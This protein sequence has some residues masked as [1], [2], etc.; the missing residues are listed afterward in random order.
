MYDHLIYDFDG[1]ISDTYPVFTRSLLEL[2]GRRGIEGDYDTAYAC[3]KVSVGHALRH[4]NVTEAHREFSKIHKAM[5]LDEQ[6]AFPEA[7]GILREALALG[8]KNYIYTH[9]GPL[10]RKLL[11]RMGLLDYFEFVLDGSYN[12]PN[13]PAPDGLNFLIDKFGIDRSRALMI[14]DRDIDVRAALAAGIAGCLF[15]PEGYYKD[16]VTDYHINSLSE[17]KNIW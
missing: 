10:A 17:M 9:T 16:C 1:T 15:D 7:E 14:G 8:K 2:L 3:L 4:Y 5:A 13:K 12:F 6:K 11:A